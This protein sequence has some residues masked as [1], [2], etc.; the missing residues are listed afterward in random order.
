MNTINV[1]HNL[2]N[3]VLEYKNNFIEFIENIS[4]HT[5][6][7]VKDNVPIFKKIITTR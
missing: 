3:I 6:T 5:T 7:S 1:E 2:N 4:G